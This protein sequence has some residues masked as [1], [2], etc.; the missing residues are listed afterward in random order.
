MTDLYNKFNKIIDRRY[1][2]STKW[3]DCD[4][5]TLAMGL[6]DMD[7]KSPD[8]LRKTLKRQVEY[9]IFGYTGEDNDYYQSIINWLK[10]Y[11]NWKIKKEWI[12]ISPGI[13]SG[14]G[15]LINSLTDPGDEIIIQ[16]PVYF[17]FFSIIKKNERQI[18]T[19]PLI[20]ENGHYTMDYNDLKQKISSKTKMLFLCNPHNPVGRVWKKEELKKLG[21]ICLENDII[22]ISD[23]IHSD[24][25]YPGSTHIPFSLLGDEFARN[26]VVCISPSKTFNIPGLQPG[27]IIIPDQKLREKYQSIREKYDFDHL[28]TMAIEATKTVYYEGEQWLKTLLKYLEDNLQ[29]LKSLTAEKIPRLN[30]IEPEGTFLVWLDFR[31]YNISSRDLYFLLKEKAGLI[32]TPGHV[33]GKA[34]EGFQR[35][36]IA[37]PRARLKEGMLRLANFMKTI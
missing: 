16:T 27:N 12:Q 14:L 24:L 4:Q 11:H 22:I 17:C 18:V 25:I 29:L 9:G 3:E 15:F 19:N 20:L 34:G 32:F 10:K 8:F 5:N 6:A 31:D 13:L 21:Q 28:N 36:N 35:I 37:C 23:E 7:F 1:T 2:N 33:F 26:S 30:V